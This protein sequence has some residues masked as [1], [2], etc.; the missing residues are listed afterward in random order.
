MTLSIE[1]KEKGLMLARANVL[2]KLGAGKPPTATD[3]EVLGIHM[4]SRTWS[5]GTPS[6]RIASLRS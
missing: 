4:M 5:A 2:K 3:M 1:V 6:T